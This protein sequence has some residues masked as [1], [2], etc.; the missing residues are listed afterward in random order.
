[1]V[2]RNAAMLTCVVASIVMLFVMWALPVPFVLSKPGPTLNVLANGGADVVSVEGAT[3]Y[4]AD[5]AL[6][7]VTISVSGGPGRS[8]SLAQV[9]R[10]VFEPHVVAEPTKQLYPKAESSKDVEE[11]GKLAMSQSKQAAKIAALRELGY[12]LTE[13]VVVSGRAE[14]LAAEVDIKPGDVLL[15]IGDAKTPTLASIK[16]ATSAL[17]VGQSVAVVVQRDGTEQTVQVVPYADGDAARLGLFLGSDFE[18][19]VD[20]LFDLNRVGGPSA[21]LVFSLAIVELLTEEPLLAGNIAATGTMAADGTVGPIGGIRLKMQAARRD[22][23]D[24]F[25]VPT[26]NCEAAHGHAP[27]G[28]NV[29]AVGTLADG[30]AAARAIKN[31]TTNQLPDCSAFAGSQQ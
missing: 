13:K 19:D 6:S 26:G 18:S 22:G 2:L 5:A 25:F 3:V 30:L 29:V 1:M 28:L 23:A 12:E 31:G 10:S 24:W 8:V 27:D 4:P 20:V 14:K 7:V 11:Q 15:A 21:G 9:L 16:A 17:V